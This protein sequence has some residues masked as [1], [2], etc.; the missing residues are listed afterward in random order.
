MP[1]GGLRPGAG[2]PK[3]NLNPLKSGKHSAQLHAA[4]HA[5]LTRD[6]IRPSSPA[7][8]T[9]TF[10][11]LANYLGDP[12]HARRKTLISNTQSNGGPCRDL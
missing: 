4:L 9:T 6:E 12:G 10:S 11:N 1:R 7:S 2:A 5:M 8:S 3:G